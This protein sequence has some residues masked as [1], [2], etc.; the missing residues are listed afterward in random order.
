MLPEIDGIGLSFQ[1]IKFP[2][3]KSGK[4]AIEMKLYRNPTSL[5]HKVI[6]VHLMI[7]LNLTVSKGVLN[8]N[9]LLIFIHL[10]RKM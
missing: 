1:N 10:N 7:T 3:I 9:I 2:F 8:I 5:E 6:C 4:I